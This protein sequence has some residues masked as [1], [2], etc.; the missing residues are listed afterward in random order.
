MIYSVFIN[1][2]HISAEYEFSIKAFNKIGSLN[3]VTFVSIEKHISG[4]GYKRFLLY[5]LHYLIYILTI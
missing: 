4:N 5:S 2:L 1:G 3:N